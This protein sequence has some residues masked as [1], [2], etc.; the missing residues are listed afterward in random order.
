ALIIM[1]ASVLGKQSTDPEATSMYQLIAINFT[2]E[3]SGWQEPIFPVEPTV[4]IMSTSRKGNT[5]INFGGEY[6]NQT[7][8]GWIPAGTP[9]ASDASLHTLLAHELALRP[10]MRPD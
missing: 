7:F 2:D 6:P 8:T 4:C 3:L 1:G 9:L 10:F 5:F